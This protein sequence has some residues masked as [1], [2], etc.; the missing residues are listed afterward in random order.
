MNPQWHFVVTLPNGQASEFKADAWSGEYMLTRELNAAIPR[1]DSVHA[2]GEQFARICL[3]ESGY[4]GEYD[5]DQRGQPDGSVEDVIG[6]E[7][8]P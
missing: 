7:D 8:S 2:T 3:I 1:A 4:E 6:V 5:F